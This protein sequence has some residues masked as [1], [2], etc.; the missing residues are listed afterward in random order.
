MRN[1]SIAKKITLSVLAILVVSFVVLQAIIIQEFKQTTQEQALKS[2]KMISESV[3]FSLRSAMNTGDRDAMRE[4]L[5]TNSKIENIRNI[6]VFR[7]QEVSEM[8]GLEKVVS[9]EKEINE[10]FTSPNDKNIN[11]QTK[12]EHYLRLIR[13]LKATN[14]CLA[15]HATSKENDVLGV[16][17]MSYSMEEFNEYIQNKTWVF[18]SIFTV[19]LIATLLFML[20][21]IKKVVINPLK[22]LSYR[23]KDLT[24]GEGDLKSRIP[25]SSNDEIGEVSNNIN[26]FI[27]QIA[28][29][30]KRIQ[31]G[32]DEIKSQILT[33]RNSSLDLD[34]S[35]QDGRE[36]AMRSHNFTKD[37]DDDFVQTKQMTENAVL[38]SNDSNKKLDT[39]IDL[40]E[41]VVDDINAASKNEQILADK[42]TQV[43]T[44]S[45]NIDQILGI[46]NEISDRT[47]LLALNAAIE[48]ARA[49]EYGRGFA[50]VAEEV[51]TLAEQTNQQIDDISKNSRSI[52]SR[53]NE[54]ND[55]LK[56]NSRSIKK[57]SNNA[58]EL[59]AIAA[60]A[61]N[62]NTNSIEMAKSIEER[63]DHSKENITEL[64]A[65]SKKSVQLAELNEHT[66]QRLLEVANSLDA[67]SQS[68]KMDLNKFKV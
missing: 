64:L 19:I 28:D 13:P 30:V 7:A 54:L 44:E 61:Q 51:R 5:E 68:F 11:V 6:R 62:A 43:A 67:I 39:V 1:L 33:L 48:A 53:V 23:T 25:I 49:G 47:N 59:R 42:T 32:A 35:S 22:L 21:I 46:I 9:T 24:N 20:F 50:V 31:D 55:S 18:L 15:C 38:L 56:E 45:K 12:D 52:I 65:Q 57:L 34:K 66:A 3:F 10:Q 40:L 60:Q 41:H 29:I 8:F 63:T 37:I 2:L 36:Q 16:L 58:S 26:I 27:K 4:A 17:D 14:D